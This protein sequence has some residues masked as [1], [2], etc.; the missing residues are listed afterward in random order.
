MVMVASL[1]FAQNE[2]KNIS[3]ITPNAASLGKYGDIPVSLYT[4]VPDIQ[5]P[6]YDITVGDFHLPVSLSYHASGIKVEEVP[7]WV[8]MGWTLNAGGV[9]NRQMVGIQDERMIENKDYYQSYI[10]T[11]LNP[12][13]T[14]SDKETAAQHCSN[15]D[16][17]S[18]V[19]YVGAG[20]L[21]QKFFLDPNGVVYCTP[22][23]KLVILPEGKYLT[24]NNTDY[25]FF[26]R[27]TIIDEKGVKY[28]FG[29]T[30]D[31]SKLN[32][33]ITQTNQICGYST[34]N[35]KIVS[36][37]YLNEI[38]LPSGESITFIYD[39]YSF[40]I[41]NIVKE[42]FVMDVME[43]ET[44]NGAIYYPQALQLKEISFPKGKIE[45]VAG[46]LRR[47][48]GGKVLDRI[49]IY[50][51]SSG[52]Y[53]EEKSF[54]L[55]TNNPTG[56][57]I[58]DDKNFRLALLAVT[59]KNK[60][61]EALTP[62][63][64]EYNRRESTSTTYNFGLPARDSYAQDIWGYY[65]G[66]ETNTKLIPS[67]VVTNNNG[68][69]IGSISGAIRSANPAYAQIG[70]LKK[71]T[72]PT[73]GTTEFVYEGN[74]ARGAMDKTDPKAVNPLNYL[75]NMDALKQIDKTNNTQL[76]NTN[77]HDAIYGQ[78]FEIVHDAGREVT[79]S[80]H[81]MYVNPSH[82]CTKTSPMGGIYGSF[83]E[84][85]G[86][87]LEK[88]NASGEFVSE[89][90][91]VYFDRFY[92]LFP[93]IYR[94]KLTWNDATQIG[95]WGYVDLHWTDLET[96]RP[97]VTD[98]TEL[99]VG[100][101]R[102]A[103]I[104]DYDPVT[105]KQ[106][107]S[108]F[109]YVFNTDDAKTGTSGT[110]LDVPLHLYTNNYVSYKNPSNPS[111]CSNCIHLTSYS[112]API[113]QTKGGYVGYKKVT[114]ITGEN[115]EGGK[116]VSYFTS[117][118][119]Y[120]DQG[121]PASH[122]WP[123]PSCTSFDWRRGLLEQQIE[124]KYLA[125][126][127]FTS[128]RKL[129]NKYQFNNAN[130]DPMYR[131]YS[132][133]KISKYLAGISTYGGFQELYSYKSN[134]YNSLS[135]SYYPTESVETLKTDQGE[136]A[137]TT[138]YSYNN[139]YLNLSSSEKTNSDSKVITTRYRYPSDFTSGVYP[140][141]TSLNMLIYPIEETTL[142]NGSVTTSKLTTYKANSNSYVPDKVYSFET[143]TPLAASSLTAFNGTTKDSRYGQ[144]PE[145][146]FDDYNPNGTI[147]QLTGRDGITTAYLWDATGNYPIAQVKGATWQQVSA[148]NAQ[149]A[150]TDSQT[151]FNNIKSL[152]PNASTTT[153]TYKPLI[154]LT[155]QTDPAG[156]KTTYDYDDFGR[157]K[158]IKDLNQN[159]V[160]KME[161]HYAGQ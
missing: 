133:V 96:T 132:N 11:I 119:D 15:Y 85:L 71:I 21:S 77:G 151:L 78:P 46:D 99:P 64:F 6:I 51:L 159:I 122:V 89:N 137:T 24:S 156:R 127:S 43:Q 66:R 158:L 112:N 141:M 67:F 80:S 152:V 27:W 161:Y 49:K 16:T 18:D 56:N 154:G 142:V 146:S 87:K 102:I 138:K 53:Q 103:K 12:S 74:V 32:V 153:F 123:F 59:E 35:P 26:D 117:P 10:Q 2:A 40:C 139:Q 86:I 108:T 84:C 48:I 47:D 125:N 61:N 75:V 25:F 111:L 144:I 93:G 70:L 124:Y 155:S 37:W 92:L 36:S 90:E 148:Y 128:I 44:S 30:R 118:E 110:V 130:S 68:S 113:F 129:V 109:S 91:T 13:A 97:T 57:T 54:V 101:L 157:L 52:T 50:S 17:E 31:N 7:S 83:W 3:P 14:N 45:F 147:R 34:D 94:V 149:A 58:S 63:N 98:N 22:A 9:I 131:F 42:T 19:F 104:T 4:G 39:T 81:V 41:Q 95:S 33:E 23:R 29:K 143:A 160:K 65:N 69:I 79:F 105:A 62:W 145:I 115:G 134:I 60:N 114:I 82:A 140:S 106:N 38:V 120:P 136:V 107:I 20:N 150:T 72:Y 55:T 8:G 1:L 126:Q 116:S 121:I 135:E 100:G 76:E 73:G 28:I 88:K 5:I